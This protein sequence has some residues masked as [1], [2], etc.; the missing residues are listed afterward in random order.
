M[1]DRRTFYI[2]DSRL[3]VDGAACGGLGLGYTH[4]EENLL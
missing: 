2:Q 4:V 3:A 1:R